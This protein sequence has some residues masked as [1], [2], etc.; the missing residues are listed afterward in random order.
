VAVVGP[1]ADNTHRLLG[2]YTYTVY[3]EL[4]S[5]AVKIVSVLEG[6]RSK[7]SPQT[8]VRYAIGCDVIDNSTDGFAEAFQATADS[9]IIIAVVGGQSGTNQNA[10]SGEHHDRI[11]LDLPGIQKELLKELYTTGKPLVVA[12]V[13][14]GNAIADVLFGDYN[15]G[16]KLPVSLLRAVGQIPSPYTRS[17]LSFFQR[18]NYVPTQSKP[19]YPFG[20]GLSYTEFTYRSLAIVPRQVQEEQEVQISCEVENIGDRVG[21]EVIQLYIRDS[22]ASVVRPWQELKGFKRVT[23]EPGE[24]RTIT[25]LMPVELLAFYDIDMSLVVEAGQFEVRVGSS[26]EDIRLRDKFELVEKRTLESR[27][28]F[29]TEVTVT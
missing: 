2:D 7:V 14:G 9:E 23:L 21:D 28:R 25:F 5:D 17:N 8:E 27:S 10:T 6:I 16:G 15:P 22:V 26:S 1:N 3:K 4:E 24:K 11:E 20:H 19:V 12:L 18:D 13:K 29:R